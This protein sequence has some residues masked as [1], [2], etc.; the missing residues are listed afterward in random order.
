M[1]SARYNNHEN[2]QTLALLIVIKLDGYV[3]AFAFVNPNA[4]KFML[5]Q[6]VTPLF[7][8]DSRLRQHSI[9]GV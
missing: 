2:E 5:L 7:G 8:M 9:I 3:S 1:T 4:E 6:Q